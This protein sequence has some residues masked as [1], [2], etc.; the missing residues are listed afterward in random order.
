L[1]A[2][3]LL[4]KS[5]LPFA[6]TA[7]AVVVPVLEEVA[8]TKSGAVPLLAPLMERLANGE[9]VPIPTLPFPRTLK[10]VALVVEA[11]AKSGSRP[12]PCE[13]VETESDANGLDVPMPMLVL[14]RNRLDVPDRSAGVPLVLVQNGNSL[15]VSED[16]VETVAEPPPVPVIVIAAAPGMEKLVQDT[17]PEQVTVDVATD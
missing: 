10:S 16:E 9:L 4:A 15:A 3:P 11:T 5:R 14:E 1:S 2:A 8:I 12:E 13:V 7:S 17:E 6:S